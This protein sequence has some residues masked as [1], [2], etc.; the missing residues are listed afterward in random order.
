[1]ALAL[2]VGLL[3]GHAGPGAATREG[4]K[5]PALQ[6]R[7]LPLVTSDNVFFFDMP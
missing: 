6:S 1:M 7:D 4:L 2:V 5:V 3:S